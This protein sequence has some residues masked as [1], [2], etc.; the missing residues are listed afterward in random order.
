MWQLNK[1]CSKAK[2]GNVGCRGKIF[3]DKIRR[4]LGDFLGG[5]YSSGHRLTQRSGHHLA[6]DIWSHV[7]NGDPTSEFLIPFQNITFTA[8][9][10]SSCTDT[11]L[12]LPFNMSTLRSYVSDAFLMK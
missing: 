5:D 11:A 9:L 2:E 12:F 7:L 6:R 10:T 3:A 1:L 4:A 8:S